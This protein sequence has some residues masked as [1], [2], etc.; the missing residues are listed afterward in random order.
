VVGKQAKVVVVREPESVIVV[1]VE[2][3]KG[4]TESLPIDRCPRGSSEVFQE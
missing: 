1:E 4:V 3:A 2:G